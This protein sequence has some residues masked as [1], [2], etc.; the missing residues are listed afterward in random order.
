MLDI[1]TMWIANIS[2]F[3]QIQK[4]TISLSTEKKTKYGIN[5]RLLYR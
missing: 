3:M 2:Y 5:G 1:I 4:S